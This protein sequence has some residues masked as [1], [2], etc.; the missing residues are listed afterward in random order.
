MA[1]KSDKKKN[2]IVSLIGGIVMTILL[3]VV[4]PVV[5]SWLIEP[6]ILEF[7][8]DSSLDLAFVQLTSGTIGAIVMFIVLVLFMLL[9][10]GGA[11]LRR[12]GVIGILGLILAYVFLLDQ[13][14]GW[15]V[16]VIIVTV[17]GL[18]SFLRDK[19]KNK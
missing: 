19:K 13:L 15:V 16:P 18:V 11:I 3:V 14:W 5:I 12:F 4:V 7:I 9:L 8:G 2:P 1:E 10:G 17:L 6:Y